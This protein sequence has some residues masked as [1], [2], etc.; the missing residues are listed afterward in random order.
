MCFTL[1]NGADVGAAGD[2]NYFEKVDR[3]ALTVLVSEA[4]A[5][6]VDAT[7][8]IETLIKVQVGQ[9]EING[10]YEALAEKMKK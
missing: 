3:E 7:E 6:G 10:A 1:A 8:A 5:S 9:K 2:E 4:L